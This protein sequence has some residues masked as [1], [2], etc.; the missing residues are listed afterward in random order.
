MEFMFL[1]STLVFKTELPRSR[2]E[3]LASTRIVPLS[4]LQSELPAQRIRVLRFR[5]N[6]MASCAD[7]MSGSVTISTS[8]APA[9]LKSTSPTGVRPSS[10]W[11]SLATSSSMWTWWI[12][13]RFVAPFS[14]STSIHPP[15]ASGRWACESW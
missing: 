10:S 15:R 6:S 13:S 11:T 7:R 4:M 9:R 8:G 2:M 3:M 1:T 12:R 14:S 5:M